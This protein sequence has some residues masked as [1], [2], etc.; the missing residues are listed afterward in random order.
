MEELKELPREWYVKPNTLE[1]AKILAK[2]FDDNR[3]GLSDLNDYYQKSINTVLERGLSKNFGFGKSKHATEISFEQFKK[4]VFEQFKKWVLKEEIQPQFEV[5]KWYKM[6]YDY[7]GKNYTIYGKFKKQQDDEFYCEQDKYIRSNGEYSDVGFINL[8]HLNLKIELLTDL[9]EIQQYLPDGHVDKI[10]KSLTRDDLIVGNSYIATN[11]NYLFKYLDING[12]ENPTIQLKVECFNTRGATVGLGLKEPF[13]LATKEKEH[14]LNCS[15]KAGKLISL[16]DSK[17]I[18]LDEIVAPEYVEYIDTKYKGIIVRVT[19]WSN[20]SYCEVIFENGVKELPFKHLVKP[21]TKEAY[22]AQF[23]IEKNM[24]KKDDYIV[25]LEI[26]SFVTNCGKNNYCFKQREDGYYVKPCIDLAGK[27][28]NDNP[29]LKFNKYDHLKDWRYATPEE[30]AEYDRLGKPFDVT[31]LDKKEEPKYA[32][33]V[34][35]C[36]TQEEWD[37]VHKTIKSTQ[38]NWFAHERY[39]KGKS[40]C[41]NIKSPEHSETV[42]YYENLNAK[43]YSFQEWCDKFGHKPD[44]IKPKEPNLEELWAEIVEL[45]KKANVLHISAPS[46][47]LT[48]QQFGIDPNKMYDAKTINSWQNEGVNRYSD[49]WMQIGGSL[50][51]DRKLTKVE[52]KEGIPALCIDGTLDVWIRAEGFI[53]YYNKKTNS[54]VESKEWIPKVGDWVILELSDLDV[55]N[56]NYV[57]EVIDTK[58]HDRYPILVKTDSKI[59]GYDRIY[60]SKVRK[61]LPHEIPIQILGTAGEIK[62]ECDIHVYNPQTLTCKCGK[63]MN[64][65]K[66]SFEK[67]EIYEVTYSNDPKEFPEFKYIVMGNDGLSSYDCI[68][69]HNKSYY[70]TNNFTSQNIIIKKASLAQKRWLFKCIAAGRYVEDDFTQDKKETNNQSITNQLLKTKL[71]NY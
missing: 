14:Q 60:C 52:L 62:E 71:I 69:V 6:N 29:G 30:I 5:G 67:G 58:A 59:T 20:Y 33:E 42:K 47:T 34:V 19:K 15:I 36:T 63:K 44:F 28:Y 55:I 65:L 7:K 27:L 64:N 8:N 39:G 31:V 9:S 1:E 66:P 18:N 3:Y 51:G 48:L 26:G 40:F 46:E 2:Y 56:K 21:S 57:G 32:Y 53:D 54:L 16:E 43:I 35:H 11:D 13:T 50:I 38:D 70:R 10:K 61:A 12:D 37:F 68:I 41:I 23:K 17:K 25:I 45:P 22:E 24:F 49:R 4:W